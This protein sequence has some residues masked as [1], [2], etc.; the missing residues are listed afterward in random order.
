MRAFVC[1]SVARAIQRHHSRR[2]APAHPITRAPAAVR[3]SCS[4]TRRRPA[5]HRPR[6][7]Q[8]RT[9]MCRSPPVATTIGR[10]LRGAATRPC[11]RCVSPPCRPHRRRRPAHRPVDRRPFSMLAPAHRPAAAAASGICRVAHRQRRFRRRPSAVRRR[12]RR[13][14]LIHSNS[15]RCRTSRRRFIFRQAASSSLSLSGL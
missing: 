2:P 11:C 10:V 7:R 14:P 15:T 3:P 8:R 9:A 6:C 13:R 12:R 4:S 1:L 5:S